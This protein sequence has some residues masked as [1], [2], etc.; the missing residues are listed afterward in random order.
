[1]KKRTELTEEQKQKNRERAKLWYQNNKE[2]ALKRI[3]EWNEKHKEARSDYHKEYRKNHIDERKEW[4]RT[5][6]GRASYLA[7]DY[8][9]FDK[10]SGRPAGDL[11][12]QWIVDNI[13][14]KP[15]AHC[16]ET[17][18]RKIGCNRLDNSKPHT[19]DN[20]E[21]CCWKCNTQLARKIQGK[22]VY[23]YTLDN[24]LIKVWETAGECGRNGF[25]QGAVSACC[26]KNFHRPGN[27]TYKGYRWSY[28]PL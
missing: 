9:N 22:N 27:D 15:C 25:G 16:G 23:Q 1:M 11:T 21:P 8:A 7:S 14:T 18:W 13:F 6:Y 17:D 5:Q 4:Y 20:V 19:T 10:L 28:E 12:A 3:K 26:R 24:E 2:R